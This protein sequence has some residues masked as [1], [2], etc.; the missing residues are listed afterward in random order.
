VGTSVSQG[1]PRTLNW[2]VVSAAYRDPRVD[3]TRVVK[4]LWRAAQS[5]PAANWAELLASP[6]VSICLD[7][8]LR[9]ESAQS[10]IR[11]ATLNIAKER[12]GSI[13]AEIGKRAIVRSFS[14]HD[15]SAAFAAEVFGEAS[16]YLVSRDLC[17]AFG[18]TDRFSS[19][20]RMIAFKDA[21]KERVHRIVREA[22]AAPSVESWVTFS[23]QVISRLSR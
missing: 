17:A 3:L 5:D 8:A 18:S 4:E 20:S 2:A 23:R 13:A 11:E 1:S 12:A 19:T 21:L 6:A 9:S 10:A 14:A 15:R 16:N 22:G 7:A